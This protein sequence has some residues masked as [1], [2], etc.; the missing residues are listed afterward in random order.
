MLEYYMIE[1]CTM[2][3]RLSLKAREEKLR[4]DARAAN[5]EKAETS[6]M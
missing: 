6:Q 1:K 3:L 4:L 2:S 5:R